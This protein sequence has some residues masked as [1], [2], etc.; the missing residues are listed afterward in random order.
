MR[1]FAKYRK[2][3]YAAMERD[4]LD[5]WKREKVFEES[6]AARPE[7][8]SYVFYDGPPFI[9]G[10]PHS[11]TLLSSIVKDVVPRFQTM[12]GYRV[13]RRWGWDCHGLPAENYVEDKLGLRDKQAVLDYGL[14]RYITACRESMI[15]TSSLWEESIDRIARW[16]EFQNAYK[17]MD[18]SYMESVWWAFKKLYGEGK[19]YEGEKILVYCT[20]CATPVSKAEVA[21]DNSYRDV[22]DP[23][24]FV[25]FELTA[26]SQDVLV[27]AVGLKKELAGSLS[28]LA[29]TTTPWTLPANTALAVNPD[30]DYALIAFGGNYHVLAKDLVGAVFHGRAGRA[31]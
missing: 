3:A 19:I 8:K 21:M 29:W 5:F 31:P 10:L 16:V 6:V 22:S 15:Q 30:L 1:K 27:A 17:T 14:E 12:R 11:G 4:I 25:K 20:R 13:E 24:V 23:S 18:P 28:L 7:E 26:E 2:A 9:T